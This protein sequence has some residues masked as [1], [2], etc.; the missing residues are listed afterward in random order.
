[1]TLDSTGYVRFPKVQSSGDFKEKT[2]TLL[3][4]HLPFDLMSGGRYE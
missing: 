3:S 2:I 4:K 1:M